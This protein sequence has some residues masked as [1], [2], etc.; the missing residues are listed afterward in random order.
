M[1]EECGL[2]LEKVI[3][4]DTKRMLASRD[5]KLELAYADV[6]LDMEDNE[7]IECRPISA[8]WRSVSV[9]GIDTDKPVTAMLWEHPDRLYVAIDGNIYV[10]S[11]LGENIH[12]APVFIGSNNINDMK[13]GY[14]RAV[15][16][17]GD[18]NTILYKTD[19]ISLEHFSPFE[20]R[21]GPVYGGHFT[22]IAINEN[23]I[24]FAGNGTSIYCSLDQA[25]TAEEWVKLKDFAPNT[26]EDIFFFFKKDK[27]F[28]HLSSGIL[29]ASDGGGKTWEDVRSDAVFN[30][31]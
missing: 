14:N 9:V 29:V 2:V 17:A 16:A 5:D 20:M 13:P 11:D 25:L 24:P 19:D 22:A 7:L 15:W 10:S 18:N 12:S 4:A 30:W 3:N 8:D 31:E 6:P 26:I 23:G 28:V 1:T 21:T 27:I